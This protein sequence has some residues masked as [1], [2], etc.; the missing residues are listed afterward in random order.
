MNI[1]LQSSLVQAAAGDHITP[2]G[3][4]RKTIEKS[5]A[6]EAPASPLL[7]RCKSSTLQIKPQTRHPTSPTRHLSADPC[8][9]R[10]Q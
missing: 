6:D 1:R 5:T 8:G 3:D 2:V 9:G 4:F 10:R 7:I